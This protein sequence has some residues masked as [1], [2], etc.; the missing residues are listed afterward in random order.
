M[1]PHRPKS[2]ELRIH[3]HYE[4]L[5]DSE[6]KLAETVLRLPGDLGS[7]S[8]TE[9]AILAGVSKASGTRFFQKLGYSSYEEAR[10]QS[11]DRQNWGSPLYLENK[12]SSHHVELKEYISEE[13]ELL[14]HSL[15]QLNYT[16]L[17]DAALA[18]IAAKRI[19]IAGF[20]NSHFLAAYLRWQIIQFRGD[21][22]T[23]PAAGETVGEYTADFT[24]SDLVIGI[25]L[26]RRLRQLTQIMEQ[27][28]TCQ[29]KRLLITDN[30]ARRIPA[31]AHWCFKVETRSPLV[32]DTATASLSLLRLIAVTAFLHSGKPG[33]AHMER[34]ERQHELLGEL[35]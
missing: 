34:V 4:D 15:G 35:E 6:R 17:H 26:R 23:L 32:F 14:K 33:R 11:R 2:V 7:R 19:W 21:V 8:V 9:L 13:V 1:A 5:S 25:G 16:E 30:T 22:Y 31:L 27:A 29:T 3:E 24:K 20:R 12:S 18:I 28:E 10:K